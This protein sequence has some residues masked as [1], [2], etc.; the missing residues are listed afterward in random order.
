MNAHASTSA[1]T[2]R[3]ASPM[4]RWRWWLF[5]WLARWEEASFARSLEL[6]AERVIL[7]DLSPDD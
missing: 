3:S 4:A 5:D 7:V 2:R 1:P 6:P